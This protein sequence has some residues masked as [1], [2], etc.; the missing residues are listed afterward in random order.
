LRNQF[1]A[2]ITLFPRFFGLECRFTPRS[3]CAERGRCDHFNSA[4]SASWRTAV[5]RSALPTAQPRWHGRARSRKRPPLRLE[6]HG[7]HRCSL[8]HRIHRP[9]CKN[10]KR[11][12]AQW[13]FRQN[14]ARI[15]IGET[16]G[17]VLRQLT[18]KTPE[19]PDLLLQSRDALVLKNPDYDATVLGLTICCFVL[20]YLATL[21][22]RAWSQH[23]RKR[24]MPL[25]Q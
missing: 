12:G 8:Q 7:A 11:F 10:K 4:L 3:R 24:Y 25:L 16:G 2:P 5:T 22:H 19:N 1:I 23:V 18:G 13:P 21:A 6:T 20:D 15:S 14:P 9:G 17:R